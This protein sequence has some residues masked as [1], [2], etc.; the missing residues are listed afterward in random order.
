MLR[1]RHHHVI[2]GAAACTGTLTNNNDTTCTIHAR[3]G[4]NCTCKVAIGF[5]LS[6]KE[7][8]E[9]ADLVL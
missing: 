9:L 7:E 5:S 4:I 1:Y 6:A 8:R 3:Y 2:A